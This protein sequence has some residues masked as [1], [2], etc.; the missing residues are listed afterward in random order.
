[1]AVNSLRERIIQSD[2][3]IL[4]DLESVVTTTRTM[5]EFSSLSTFALTQFPVAA[6]VGRLPVPKEKHSSRRMGTVDQIISE[7][8][9]DVFVY[10]MANENTD[11]EI[12]TLLDDIWVALYTDPNRGNL[13]M[14]TEL[15][16]YEGVDYAAPFAAFKVSCIHQYKHDTGGI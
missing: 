1:M 10:L 12:S 11:T 5:P 3:D 7:L 9:V 8:K 16:L 6:V 13:V 15:D 14:K 4:S 2:V